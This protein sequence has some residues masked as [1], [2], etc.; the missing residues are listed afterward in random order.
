LITL[1]D[2]VVTPKKE[3]LHEELCNVGVDRAYNEGRG[4]GQ[5]SPKHS[6]H[7]S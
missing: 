7:C 1:I 2:E 3:K 6:C 5:A 4:E